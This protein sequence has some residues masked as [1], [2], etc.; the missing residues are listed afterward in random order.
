MSKVLI[1]LNLFILMTYLQI[2]RLPMQ[3]SCVTSV[4]SRVNPIKLEYLDDAG[5]PAASLLE[6]KLLVN[7]VISEE[8][9]GAKFMS[10]DLKDFFLASPMAN[11][12]YMKIHCKHIPQEIIDLYQ[13]EDKFHNDY[14]YVKI[15]KGMY[16]LE[17][18][19][20]LAY[21]HLVNNLAPFS[22]TPIPHTVGL[23]KHKTRPISFCLCV[24]DF[25]IKYKNREDIDHFLKSLEANYKY[26][27]DWEGRNFCGLTF[28]WRYDEGYVDVSMPTYINKILH[29]FQHQ[30]L[31]KAQ[32]SPFAVTPLKPLQ[33]GERQYATEKDTTALLDNKRKK[34]VQS[35]V[36]SVLYY[37]RAIDCTL[38]PALNSISAMQA[39]L[40]ITTEKQCNRVLDYLATYPHIFIR[41]HASDMQLLPVANQRLEKGGQTHRGSLRRPAPSTFH[42]A[43]RSRARQK[44]FQSK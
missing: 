17:Q 25:G 13:L 35:I 7:S 31:S 19:A 38:L 1:Q 33:P 14:I 42:V 24:D 11:P 5:S 40:I 30:R 21:Q 44:T 39:K 20:I 41:Y 32:K 34:Q 27:T 10:T 37:A 15:K 26:T 9:Q 16:G 18:A 2:K 4:L 3:T 29:K 8:K 12:K 22:Y 23:W 36:G 6:T 43:C 28:N